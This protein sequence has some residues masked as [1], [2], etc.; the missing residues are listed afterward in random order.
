MADYTRTFTTA[1]PSD[2]MASINANGNIGPSVLQIVNVGGGT[3]IFEFDD[4]LTSP[5]VTEFDG[6]LS[7]WVCPTPVEDVDGMTVEDG[8]PEDAS[9]ETL[10]SSERIVQYVAA[11]IAAVSAGD[12]NNV[13]GKTFSVGFAHSS[14][15]AAN[16]WLRLESNDSG[17]G[18]NMVPFIVPWDSK[19]ISATYVNA[20]NQTDCDVELWRSPLHQEPNTNK[21]K[22][23]E[24]QIRNQRSAVV[25][26][27]GGSTVTFNRGDKVA[28]YLE[29]QGTNSNH[30]VVQ[31]TFLITANTV[32]NVTDNFT[33]YF[34]GSSSGGDDDDD[35]D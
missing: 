9:S 29:D 2:L 15:S 14:S 10:W 3:S 5:E 30:P 25:T 27:F 23:H 7:S 20:D 22:F 13:L 18:S 19:L 34:N 26:D 11:E 1:C 31:L 24:F 28:V 4:T 32:G 12:P 17:A 33:N 6:V 8:S 21:T 16:T 35:D